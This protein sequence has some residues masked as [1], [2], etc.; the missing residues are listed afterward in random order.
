MNPAPPLPRIQVRVI[1]AP[2]AVF[3]PG[4]ADL[5]DHIADTGSISAAARQMRMSYKRA[6]QLVDD[7][8][9]AFNSPLVET[10][11]GGAHG[12]GASLTQYGKKVAATY[13]RLQGKVQL[14][15]MRELAT[16]ARH[17]ASN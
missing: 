13:R 9:R 14:A 12:G 1:L 3:G 2:G 8:N 4:K 5:L 7:M 6:W 16:L 15:A 17:A 11:A 10:S